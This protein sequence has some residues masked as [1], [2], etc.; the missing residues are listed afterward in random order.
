MKKFSIVTLV[1][2]I[3]MT[4]SSVSAY[5][6]RFLPVEEPLLFVAIGVILLIASAVLADLAE[7]RIRLNVIC[8]FANAVAL[9]ALI[10]AW[11]VFRGFDNPLWLM[12]LVS[13]ATVLY[14]CF[15]FLFA[16]IPL[17]QEHP[18][19]YIA[20]FLLLS[21]AS[22]VLLLIFTQTTFVSTLGYYAIVELGF[23]Y[24]MCVSTEDEETLIRT[25][26]LS[27]Y[28]LFGVAVIV[29]VVILSDGDADL[30]IDLGFDLIPDRNDSKKKQDTAETLTKSKAPY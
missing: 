13:L 1:S 29:A 5:L 8:S 30:D 19:I 20:V 21:G 17:F 3:F 2:F 9:G 25:L 4:V 26:T 10:R 11:Y 7:R 28:T 23:I 18:R 22:Y 12:L 27:T 15:F 24:A 6:L 16:H 14:L